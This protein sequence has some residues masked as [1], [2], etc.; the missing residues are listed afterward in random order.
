[1]NLR[2]NCFGHFRVTEVNKPKPS[3]FTATVIHFNLTNKRAMH[4]ILSSLHLPKL[5]KTNLYKLYS[6]KTGWVWGER[7]GRVG[8]ER[9]E[10]GIP[11]LVG[12]GRNQEKFHS[13][14]WHFAVEMGQRGKPLQ[15][16][17]G[18]RSKRY[19]CHPPL[20][21]YLCHDHFTKF[22]KIFLHVFCSG[23]PG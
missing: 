7:G 22:F 9:A 5:L 18:T 2:Q 12:T 8:E 21:I 19:P 20:P 4:F 15:K 16:G 6:G 17:V 3:R 14:L 11:K 13:V 23:F 1:M 10:S